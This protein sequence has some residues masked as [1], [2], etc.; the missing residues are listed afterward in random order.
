MIEDHG[1]NVKDI[2]KW[3]SKKAFRKEYGKIWCFFSNE[4]IKSLKK[5]KNK[6]NE[7]GRVVDHP[8]LANRTTPGTPSWWLGVGE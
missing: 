3:K 8:R 2:T 6:K 5:Q 1:Y 4:T 7:V